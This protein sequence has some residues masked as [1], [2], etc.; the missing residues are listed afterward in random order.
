MHGALFG[1]KMQFRQA[2]SGLC[3]PRHGML[4]L[5]GIGRVLMGTPCKKVASEPSLGGFDFVAR[6]GRW[7]LFVPSLAKGSICSIQFRSQAFLNSVEFDRATCTLSFIV[8]CTEESGDT[9]SHHL[10]PR[11]VVLIPQTNV[12]VCVVCVLGQ[13][14]GGICPVVRGPPLCFP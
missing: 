12:C 13:L 11:K 3:L 14:R 2:S 9:L 4:S 1:R 7:V 5:F 6:Q 8:S 10:P